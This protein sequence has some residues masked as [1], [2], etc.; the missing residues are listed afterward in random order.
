MEIFNLHGE[1]VN[2]WRRHAPNAGRELPQGP[3]KRGF[4]RE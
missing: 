4:F 2:S 3:V 1:D